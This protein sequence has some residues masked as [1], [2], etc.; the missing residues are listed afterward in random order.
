MQSIRRKTFS[1]C[2]YYLLTAMLP[3]GAYLF[4]RGPHVI[5]ACNGCLQYSTITFQSCLEAG[6]NAPENVRRRLLPV[7]SASMRTPTLSLIAAQEHGAYASDLTQYRD[8]H[9][10]TTRL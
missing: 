3:V 7:R 1:L 2:L 5:F 4:T 9:A 10:T 6:Y 8:G